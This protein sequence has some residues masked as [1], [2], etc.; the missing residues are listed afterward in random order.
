[1]K[2]LR[3]RKLPFL[4]SDQYSGKF[5]L[6]DQFLDTKYTV[7]FLVVSEKQTGDLCLT[8]TRPTN[9]KKQTV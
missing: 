1:M 4:V 2:H 8:L 7:G 9:P 3:E 5:Y 6:F